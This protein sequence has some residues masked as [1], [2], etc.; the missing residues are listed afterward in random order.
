MTHRKELIFLVIGDFFALNLAWASFYWL[1]VHSG[2]FAFQSS[3]ATDVTSRLLPESALLIYGFWM[4]LF[5]FFGLYRPWYVRAPFDE[6]VTMLKTLGVGTIL[7]SVI[8]WWDPLDTA[9]TTANDPRILGLTYWVIACIFCVGVRSLT[10]YAQRRLLEAGVG[11]RASIIIGDTEN[12][13][14]L[15][16]RV[17]DYPRLGYNVI[18][19]VS[20][21]NHSGLAFGRTSFTV[22]QHVDRRNHRTSRTLEVARLGSTEELEDVIDRHGVKEVLIALGTNEHEKL[23]DVIARAG[24]SNAGLKIVPD[25]YDIVSGQARTRTIYG[26]P[27]IDIN[28]ILQ[29]PW[30]EAAK[31]TLDMVAGSFF[32]IVGSPAWLALAAAIKLSSSGPVLFSQER[33]GKDGRLFRMHKFRSMYCDAEQGS[34]VYASKNDPRVTPLGRFMRKSHLD[35]VPQFW[36]VLKGQMSLVGPRPEREFFVKQLIQDIPYYNRRQKVRPGITGLYQATFDKYDESLDDVRQRV[37]YDLMYI[38]S[39]SFRLDVKILFRTAYIMLRG[40]GQA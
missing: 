36:N 29:R 20:P 11:T 21:S 5:I 17:A 30:E 23:I 32:L 7:L 3:P 37:K 2:W 25:L 19:F 12:A 34:P 38:E 15:A 13:K 10:R 14:E 33:V 4:V 35:E 31:R 18:G 40:R 28:P 22:Q 8:I 39:M 1:R 16:E 27:L 26:F 24:K 9:S 6:I